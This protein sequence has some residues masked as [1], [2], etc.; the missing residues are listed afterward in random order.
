MNRQRLLDRFLRYVAIDTTAHEHSSSAPSS[1]NQ[2]A[3]GRMLVDELHACGVADASQDENGI[4]LA[5]LPSN[6]KGREAPTIAWCAHLDTSPETS[7]TNI[8]PRVIEQYDG[9]DI[10][11]TG[12]PRQVIR[13]DETPNLRDVVGKTLIVTDG[14]TL[15]GADDKSGVAVIME[16]AEWLVEH[17]EIPHG[18]LR[19]LFTCDE[20][21]G[22]GTDHVDLATVGATA[23]Y[24]LDSEGVDSIDVETFSADVAIVEIDGRNIHPSI[25]KG[26]MVNAVRAAARLVDLLPRETDSPETT[27]ERQGFL[28]PY[29][30]TGGVGRATVHVLLRDFETEGL[31]RFAG[32]LEQAARQV[33]Q[34]F[35][36]AKVSIDRRFQYRNMREGLEKEPRAVE[37]AEAA[38]RALGVTPSRTIVR[39]GTDG[40][41]LTEMGLPT[42]NLGSGQHTP[43]SVLE[44]ACLDE[45]EQM[46]NVLV[47]LAKQWAE[48][49]C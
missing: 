40:S 45:M 41:R 16:A 9:Q 14:T 47:E 28:H 13:V 20:E 11:L 18:P 3:L 34:E 48:Q 10:P 5:T 15:L 22:R 7:G 8:H 38:L 39:G 25:A 33:E 12:D 29:Q 31:D 32:L 4:V 42:P 19:L 2:L 23:C 27:H 17:P 44:W 1:P 21:I 30:M 49:E 36:G 46:G 26:R 43:H 6:L 35:P 37:L 24:T